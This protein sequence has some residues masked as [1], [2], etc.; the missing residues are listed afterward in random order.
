MPWSG[1]SL[2][3][4]RSLSKNSIKF[5]WNSFFCYYNSMIYRVAISLLV[6]IMLLPWF[7][8][9]IGT[10]GPCPSCDESTCSLTLAECRHSNGGMKHHGGKRESDAGSSIVSKTDAAEHNG[11]H[12]GSGMESKEQ[13]KER[14]VA[15]LDN[16]A[17]KQHECATILSCAT[18]K[19]DQLY[20]SLSEPHIITLLS[21]TGP[22]LTLLYPVAAGNDF[23][24]SRYPAAIERP[25]KSQLS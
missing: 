22:G 2:Q 20:V 24:K 4:A 7:S 18:P 10:L 14:G 23:S 15:S 9:A 21:P 6:I 25:P 1:H 3:H 17:S 11:H 16:R 8:P 19:A 5:V 13:E 12:K